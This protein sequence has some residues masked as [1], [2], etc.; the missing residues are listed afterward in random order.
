MGR[1]KSSSS[2]DFPERDL[3]FAPPKALNAK[4]GELVHSLNTKELTITLGPAG[5]GKTYLSSCFAGFFYKS[6]KVKRIVITRPTV[7]TGKSIGFFPGTLDEKMAPWT[8]PIIDVLEDYLSKGAVE[9]MIKN[10][11]L[12]VVPFETIRGRS[13]QDTFVIL[14]EAQNTTK[15]EIKAFVTRLGEGSTTVVNGDLSQS[16]L[17]EANGLAY[18]IKTVKSSPK[19]REAV[20][21]IEFKSQDVVRSGLCK[22]FV[23]AFEENT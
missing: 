1:K 8:R 16:D 5:T 4:Q 23:E 6:G 18:L 17:K 21:L 20:G 13:W 15:E 7:P 22:L 2:K 14:D 12:E 9:T 19:L 3:P 11:K 10:G